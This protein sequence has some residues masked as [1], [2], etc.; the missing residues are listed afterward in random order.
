MTVATAVLVLAAVAGAPVVEVT[1]V[2]SG[3]KAEKTAVKSAE[4]KRPARITSR[5]TYYDR[6]EGIAI[7]TGAVHVDDEQYQMHADKAY[8]FTSSTNELHR[9]VAI[10]NVALT[11]EARRAYADKISYYRADGMVVLYGKDGRAAEVRE[12]AKDGDRVVKG[13]K[14]KFWIDSEQVEIIKSDITAPSSGMQGGL[15]SVL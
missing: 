10:G 7:F 11:N 14:I 3:T 9:I 2:A 13:E 4:S 8:V 5:S 12:E 1:G 6:K 15:K